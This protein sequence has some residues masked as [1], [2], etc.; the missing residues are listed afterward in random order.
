MTPLPRRRSRECSRTT[1]GDTQLLAECLRQ[2]SQQDVSKGFGVGHATEASDFDQLTSEDGLQALVAVKVE[3][4]IIFFDR[5]ARSVKSPLQN[6]PVKGV[7]LLSKRS[8]QSP[9]S[10]P[11]VLHFSCVM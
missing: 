2:T 8:K 11:A 1:G 9:C 4:K 7:E 3:G 10:T 5:C 6:L